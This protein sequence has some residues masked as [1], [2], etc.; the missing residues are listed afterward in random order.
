MVAAGKKEM[1]HVYGDNYETRDGT[2]IRDYIHV[3]DLCL[4]LLTAAERGPANTPYE[5]LGSNH[6]WT[7]HEVLDVME[8]VTGKSMNRKVVE[9][10]PGD[11]DVQVVDKLSE[12]CNLKKTIEDMCESQYQLE[13]NKNMFSWG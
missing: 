8:E 10:R 2:C 3:S 1:V 4:A 7:V 13:I 11:A 9:R 12:Y 6:G 5:C